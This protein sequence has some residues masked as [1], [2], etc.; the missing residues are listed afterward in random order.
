MSG[1]QTLRAWL[2]RCR[3]T[4]AELL[5]LAVLAAGSL[6]GLGLVWMAARPGMVPPPEPVPSAIT[7][8][9]P[10]AVGQA[11]VVVHVAGRV[12]APGVYTLPGGS[13]VADALEAAGGPRPRA[14]LEALNLARPLA[15]G[16][17]LLVGDRR[18]S[19]PPASA[20]TPSAPS[21]TP[22]PGS[23]PAP[24]STTAPGASPGVSPISLNQATA[25]Q[26]ELLPEIG[27]VLAGR[28]ISHREQIGGFTAV[29]QLRDVSG[30]GEK[31]FQAL[32]GL[33][34]P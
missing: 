3:C 17:Q 11:E 23:T 19:A 31:T 33:V 13:R 4:P 6:A 7:S 21:A 5:A 20:A 12:A 22:S 10:L 26:L 14:A 25:A 2:Q 18:S 16:E 28:I 30:I 34:T 24:G 9:G 1:F 15:D 8:Q 32:A 29:E 27:P